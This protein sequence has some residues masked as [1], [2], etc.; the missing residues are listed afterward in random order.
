MISKSA[1]NKITIVLTVILLVLVVIQFFH[2]P[3]NNDPSVTAADISN[4]YPLP[5]NV[6]DIS[7]KACYDCHSNNTRYPW[8]N[9]IQPV[10]WWLNDHIKDGKRHLN[11]SEFGGYKLLK[12]AKKLHETAE[13]S[14]EGEMP[15]SSYT[16][17]HRDAVLNETEKKAVVEWA[18]NLSKE[19]MAKVPPEEIEKDKQ[20]RKELQQQKEKK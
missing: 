7:V 15:L 18:D 2:P 16:F 14:E 1:R 11:F 5:G 12:Q 8:Y 4:T 20:R 10:A 9:N 17:I 6:K 13:E 3:K 19:V